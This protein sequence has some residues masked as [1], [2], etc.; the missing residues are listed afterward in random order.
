MNDNHT[1]IK[2]FFSFLFL[3]ITL[4]NLDA[5]QVT[6]IR[7]E[8][9]GKKNIIYYD[10]TGAK[11]GRKFNISVYCSTGGDRNFGMAIKS[12]SCD[13]GKNVTAGYNKKIIWDVLKDRENLTGDD[14]R[15][16]GRAEIMGGTIEMAFVEGGTFQMGSNIGGSD[17]KPAHTVRIKSFYIGKYE[18]TQKQWREVMEKNPSRFSGCDNCPVENVSWNDVQEFIS[19]LNAKT[20]M[21]YRLPTE[22]EWEYAARGGNKSRGYEYS[23]SNKVGDVAWYYENSEKKTHAIGLRQSN[24]LGIYDMSGNVWEWC[25]DTYSHIYYKTTPMDNPKG[26]YTSNYRVLRGGSWFNNQDSCRTANRNR[27]TPDFSYF[28]IGFR[29]ARD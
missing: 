3:F 13:V 19:K 27:L 5:Q 22:A 21:N 9:E 17:E 14:I 18:V 24:E 25:S 11:Q 20:G 7:A 10:L 23:G 8:Q 1:V 4:V 6:N 28:N 26:P 15:F 12:V 2:S 29:L 16:E